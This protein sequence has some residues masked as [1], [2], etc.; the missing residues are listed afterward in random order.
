MKVKILK[1]HLNKAGFVLLIKRG[2][3]SHS[4][5]RHSLYP[6]SVVQSGKDN[7]DAK[8][9]QVK[10]IKLVLRKVNSTNN[11]QTDYDPIN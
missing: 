3:G 8:P 5:W 1:S 7:S 11:N 4:V 6:I 10:T 9:Y 2:K